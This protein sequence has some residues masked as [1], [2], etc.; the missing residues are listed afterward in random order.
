M[1]SGDEAGQVALASRTLEEQDQRD[2]WAFQQGRDG[3]G[4]S[5]PAD[6]GLAYGRNADQRRRASFGYLGRSDDRRPD[7]PGNPATKHGSGL[8]T[9]HYRIS[10][11]QLLAGLQFPHFMAKSALPSSQRNLS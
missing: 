1:G 11:K 9:T 4:H 3:P 10:R 5:P 8:R 6:R 2:P 7:G